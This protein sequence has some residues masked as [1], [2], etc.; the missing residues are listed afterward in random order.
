MYLFLVALLIK[1]GL[2]V[3]TASALVRSIAF[4]RYLYKDERNLREKIYFTL[5]IALPMAIYVIVRMTVHSF[6]AADLSLPG[7]FLIGLMAG[8]WSG[9]LGGAIISAPAFWGGHE[10]LS[11]PFCL[12]AGWAGGV[13]R[14]VAPNNA[15][16]WAFSPFI[17]L[18]LW[19]W[20]RNRLD[21]PFRDWQALI[22][23]VL[24][25][26]TLV[27]IE[28]GR[29]FPVRF[30]SLEPDTV[31]ET[32]LMLFATVLA[33]AIP[34][35]VWNNTRIEGQLEEQRR[36][37]VQARLDALT[38]Q[39]NPHFLFN[40]LNSIASLI[41]VEP[42][43]ARLLVIKLSSILRRLLQEHEHYVPLRQ[44]IEFVE[45]YLAIELARF[46]PEQ[47]KV[48]YDLEAGA[49]DAL[50]PSMLLQ[51]IV[52]NSIRHGL[53]QQLHG[54]RIWI[55]ARLAAGRVSLSV[56]DDGAGFRAKDGSARSGIGLTN[57]RE[58]LRVLYGPA[59]ELH[60]ESAAG[61]GAKVEILLPEVEAAPAAAAPTP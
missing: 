7:A 31:W 37:L 47:L 42:D 34:I 51:P 60:I 36:L 25:G 11:L 16:I 44:E 52:E 4:K 30:Y 61:A 49:L 38:R 24:F 5:Y 39:I 58:R 41:R 15:E 14:R 6:M 57:V 26:L 50:V 35:K 43:R 53:A 56:E 55:R 27:Q 33:V 54:G 40:T 45:D 48:E 21:R 12:F 59:A 18:E 17:D 28:L 13:C 46:G 32:I 9:V 22:F 8:Q 29:L 20:L 19:R 1:L 2:M 3:A 23:G 10:W